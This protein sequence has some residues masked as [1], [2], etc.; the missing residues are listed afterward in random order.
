[1]KLRLRSNL[2]KVLAGERADVREGTSRIA[3]DFCS[4]SMG[5]LDLL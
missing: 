5:H 4:G 1:M 3:A 2:F